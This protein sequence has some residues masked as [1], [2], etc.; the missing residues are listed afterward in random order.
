MTE[1]VI[2]SCAYSLIHT[3]GFVR[4]GS[5]PFREAAAGP[6]PLLEEIN[7][8]L[9][10]FEAAV[11]YPPNQVFIGN[12]DPDGLNDIEQ[13]WYENPVTGASRHGPFGE[14]MPEAE[15]LSGQFL[16]LDAGLPGFL[17]RQPDA[18]GAS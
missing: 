13:P 9:R 12:M 6:E 5:K 4:Y 2:K 18:E 3:P 15:L 8:H 17:A 10:S 14:I 7:E 1:P 16:C 11:E